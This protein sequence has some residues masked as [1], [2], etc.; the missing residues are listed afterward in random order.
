MSRVCQVTGKKPLTGSNVSQS[1]TGWGN[2]QS[3]SI[4]NSTDK[5]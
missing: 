2:S 3:I 5:D 1:Q 4:G